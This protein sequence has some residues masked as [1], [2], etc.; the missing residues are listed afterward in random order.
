MTLVCGVYCTA[1]LYQRR[2]NDTVQYSTTEL[3]SLSLHQLS[4]ETPTSDVRGPTKLACLVCMPKQQQ[5]KST[6]LPLREGVCACQTE[7][8]AVIHAIDQD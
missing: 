8:L 2:A 7:S 6:Q 3:E 1:L 5:Q 4:S